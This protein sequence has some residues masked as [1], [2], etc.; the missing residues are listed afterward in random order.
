M[1]K[2]VV[3]TKT[4]FHLTTDSKLENRKRRVNDEFKKRANNAK[5]WHWLS[6]NQN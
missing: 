1:T 5:I 3:Y 6:P 4:T 2:T